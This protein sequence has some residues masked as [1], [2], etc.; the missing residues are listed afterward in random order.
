MANGYGKVLCWMTVTEGC[1]ID[2]RRLK[3]V[4]FRVVEDVIVE[5]GHRS[6]KERVVV[7]VTLDLTMPRRRR[8]KKPWR[9]TTC[10]LRTLMTTTPAVST[11]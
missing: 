5:G 4:A 7:G 3:W 8:A 6:N 2:I 9:I 10:S 1:L 11:K